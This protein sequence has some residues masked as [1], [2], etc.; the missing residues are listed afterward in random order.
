[1][2][3]NLMV[4]VT[5]F[6][7]VSFTCNIPQSLRSSYQSTSPIQLPIK[8]NAVWFILYQLIDHQGDND[9][10]CLPDLEI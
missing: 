8:S 1:M 10:D 4:D 6:F 3:N 2:I 9:F 7:K 5:G